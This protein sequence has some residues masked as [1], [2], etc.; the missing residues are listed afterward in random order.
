MEGIFG[1]GKKDK[2]KEKE[3]EDKDKKSKDKECKDKVRIFRYYN[4]IILIVYESI[5]FN[6][7]TIMYD[8][9]LSPREVLN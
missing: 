1:F 3:K 7:D 4:S 9:H 5:R 8:K 6:T 2:D